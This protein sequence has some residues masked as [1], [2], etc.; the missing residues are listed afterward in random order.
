MRRAALVIGVDRVG[1]LPPLRAAAAGAERVAAWLR[2]EGYEVRCLTDRDGG[3]VRREQVS[4][5]LF[6][7]ITVPP[8]YGMLVVYFSGHGAWQARSDIWLLSRAP[9]RPD[10]AINLTAAMDLAR[11]SGIPNVVFV[12]DACRTLPADRAAAHV[13]GGAVFPNHADLDD[14]GCIDVFRAAGEARAAYELREGD[15]AYSALTAALL[16]AYREPEPQMVLTLTIDGAEAEVVPNRKLEDYLRRKVDALLAGTRPRVRQSIRASV[17]SADDVYIG[18]VRRDAPP[19]MSQTPP[20]TPSPKSAT[21]DEGRAA[22]VAV[23]RALSRGARSSS[24][25]DQPRLERALGARMLLPDI[26]TEAGETGFVLRG[27]ALRDARLLDARD[28]WRLETVDPQHL[29][30]QRAM[31][32][33]AA[34]QRSARACSLLLRLDDG[35]GVLLAVLPGFVGHLAFDGRGLIHASYVRPG[36]VDEAADRFRAQ[37]ALAIEHDTFRLR[38][39]REAEAFAQRAMPLRSVDPSLA[40]Y[41][42]HAFHQ[43]GNARGLEQ[44]LGCS[45]NTVDADLFDV[46]LLA[47]RRPQPRDAAYPLVPLAPMLTQAWNLLDTREIA[48][49]A[50]LRGLGDALCD[51]LWTTFTAAGTERLLAAIERGE[52]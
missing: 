33:Q 20:A 12:S 42:A 45:R 27:A 43:A 52:L 15:V 23:R 16:S 7:L 38:S 51:T 29:R 47:H 22:A 31:P 46:R 1:D 37:V 49:P 25:G 50:A 21:T 32:Q 34:P 36:D 30:L 3:E 4:D 24:A 13:L 14:S 44:A 28:A 11:A 2:E 48:M 18:R 9:A 40:V 6:E 35:R 17:P 19:P 41:A 10:E 39:Q 5:A 8:R 26:A